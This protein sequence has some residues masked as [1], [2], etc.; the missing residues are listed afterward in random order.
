[1]KFA[2]LW[3]GIAAFCSFSAVAEP[4]EITVY[5]QNLA[6]IKKSQP[7]QLVK[8]INQVVFDEVAQ[9]MKPESAFIYGQGIKVLEQ[10]YDYAGI[11]YASML[12]AFVGQNVM[13]VRTNPDSGK[14]IF[15]RA[16]LIAVNGEEPVLKFDYGIE[17][18]FPGRVIFEQVPGTLNTTPTLMAKIEA[19]AE[20]IKQLNLAYLATGF[21]WEANYVAHVNDDETLSLLGRAAIT[22]H[23][24]S[25]YEQAKINLI[26]GDVNTVAQY[27]QPRLMKAARGNVMMA[28]M[29]DSFA[30]NAA[31]MEAPVMLDSYYVYQIPE[32]TELKNGQ[33][34]QVSF[35][36]APKVK[37]QK[38]GVLVSALNFNGSK[39]IFKDA[40]PQVFY[41]FIN[42]ADDGLGLPL[43]Q[44]K[45]SFYAPDDKGALQFIG[46]N[47]IDHKAAGQK[48]S[49]QLGKYFDVYGEGKITEVH[50]VKQNTVKKTGQKC[51]SIV[52][53]YRYLVNYQMV[54]KSQKKIH[55]AL[56]QAL[57]AQ[58]VIV[59]ETLTG[60]AGEGNFHEWHFDLESGATQD[61]EMVVEHE[62]EKVDCSVINL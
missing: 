62:Q 51:P 54:N 10:N 14:N 41:H 40:H 1:M 55:L 20:G 28:A 42:D 53:N 36:T 3:C 46:E 52:T 7:V 8:G 23:S 26:A 59:S 38:E 43:P 2:A 39:G 37:Y 50:Q 25:G 15:E 49:L 60:E 33:I 18:Q 22:N 44:G 58:A 47:V 27:M 21:E 32:V 17:T 16:Q 4:I 48:I 30:E 35:L 5:N 9:Q 57:P 29:A 6:M 61:I 11:N 13:T 12:N 34:K 31:V 24:G 45:I 56:K 19:V